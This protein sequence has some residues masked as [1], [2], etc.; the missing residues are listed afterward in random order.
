MIK[1]FMKARLN[2]LVFSLCLKISIF[3]D[4]LES[5]RIQQSNIPRK[6]FIKSLYGLQH[7]DY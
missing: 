5:E 1:D 7:T 2:K 6:A 4:P 3:S